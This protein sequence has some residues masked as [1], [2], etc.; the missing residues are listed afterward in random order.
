M[1]GVRDVHSGRLVVVWC[2]LGHLVRC[3]S[4]SRHVADVSVMALVFF[5]ETGVSLSELLDDGWSLSVRDV[6]QV[7]VALS[8]VSDDKAE[9]KFFERLSIRFILQVVINI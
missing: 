1:S 8:T 4:N 3:R 7:S 2:S 6:R 9:I 5:N